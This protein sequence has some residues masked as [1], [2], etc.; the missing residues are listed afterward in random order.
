MLDG[1]A[2]AYTFMTYGEVNKTVS[3]VGSA[4]KAVGVETGSA[5]GVYAVNSPEWMMAMKATDFCGAMTVPLY[6]T[7]GADAVEYIIKHSGLK[8]ICVST[9]KLATITKVL[10]E[11]KDQIVQVIVWSNNSGEDVDPDVIAVCNTMQNSSVWTDADC[12]CRLSATVYEVLYDRC[13]KQSKL[14]F[15]LRSGPSSLPLV[16]AIYSRRPPGI[17]RTCARSCIHQEPLA[18]Q[19]V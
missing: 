6:D 17:Q 16:L 3:C 14:A 4:L 19:K 7:F 9:D 1:K 2:Q 5:V 11:V 12:R 15:Q 13:R 8:V 10:P 18:R